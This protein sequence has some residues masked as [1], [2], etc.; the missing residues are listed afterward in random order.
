MRWSPIFEKRKK[1]GKIWAKMTL[2]CDGAPFSKNEKK[3]A[4]FGPKKTDVKRDFVKLRPTSRHFYPGV[5]YQ[6]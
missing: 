6:I 4:K 3:L 2:E 1:I 5:I